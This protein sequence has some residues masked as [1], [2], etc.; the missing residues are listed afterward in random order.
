MLNNNANTAEAND[1]RR[2]EIIARERWA[3]LPPWQRTYTSVHDLMNAGWLW[4]ARFGKNE[5]RFRERNYSWGM[6]N[7][8]RKEATYKSQVWQFP[9]PTKR[10]PDCFEAADAQ[11]DITAAIAHVKP[12]PKVSEAL[13]LRYWEGY[14]LEETAS[15]LSISHQAVQHRLNRFLAKCKHY[16]KDAI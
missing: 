11:H 2:L 9:Q 13:R 8:I 14:T 12:S 10:Q 7:H 1:L 16:F 4:H 6:T 5:P 15:R 3:T